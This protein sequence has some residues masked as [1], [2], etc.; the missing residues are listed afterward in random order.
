VLAPLLIVIGL[1]IG[2]G[3]THLA[4]VLFGGAKEGFEA[5]F[6]VACYSVAPSVLAIVPFCGGMI[7]GIWRIVLMI[8]GIAEAHG[9]SKGI[10]AAAVLVPI[11]VLCCCCAGGGFLAALSV[12]MLAQRFR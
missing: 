8:I 11:V 4:L 10:A 12:P 9:V 2:A 7:G 5:T 3:I 1:F 6:R